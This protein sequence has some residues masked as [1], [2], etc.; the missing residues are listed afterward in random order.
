MFSNS[1]SNTTNGKGRSQ[2][3]HTRSPLTVCP[4]VRTHLRPDCSYAWGIS[5]VSLAL[6]LQ[7]CLGR[8]VS[9]VLMLQPCLALVLTNSKITIFQLHIHLQFYNYTIIDHNSN[10]W[11]LHSN[12][13]FKTINGFTNGEAFKGFKQFSGR[14]LHNITYFL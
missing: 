1:F 8:V 10:S 11:N 7:V 5:V 9:L 12:F 2:T 3:E 13:I 4:C 14:K 6:T